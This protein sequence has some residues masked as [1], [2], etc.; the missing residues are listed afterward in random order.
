MLWAFYWKTSDET[1]LRHSSTSS[2][3]SIYSVTEKLQLANV[4]RGMGTFGPILDDLTRGVDSYGDVIIIK[5]DVNDYDK[6]TWF[7]CFRLHKRKN[8]NQLFLYRYMPITHLLAYYKAIAYGVNP[9]SPKNL[10]Q[11]VKP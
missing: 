10:S 4:S 6:L 11:V 5:T 2:I 1:I 9:H 3:F 7:N 8:W